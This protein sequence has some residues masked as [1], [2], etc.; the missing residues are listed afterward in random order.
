MYN[1]GQPLSR[2]IIAT[3]PTPLIRDAMQRQNLSRRDEGTIQVVPFADLRDGYLEVVGN[4]SKG[5]APANSVVINRTRF[6]FN[7]ALG[8]NFSCAALSSQLERPARHEGGARQ[9]VPA[10]KI[11]N[12]HVEMAGN[13]A[14]R[15]A[16]LNTV[17]TNAAAQFCA[18]F[19]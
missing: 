17:N 10:A 14:E 9:V 7:G 19:A 1:T 18:V 12:A 16:P 4:N 3:K 8:S 11:C 5:V 2:G 6:A 15:I 13:K